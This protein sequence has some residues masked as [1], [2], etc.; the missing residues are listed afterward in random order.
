MKH[1]AVEKLTLS[2]NENA[3]KL[4]SWK[5]RKCHRD[6]KWHEKL[7]TEDK[8]S[9]SRLEHTIRTC[10]SCRTQKSMSTIHRL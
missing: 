2:T 10:R 9:S 1:P 4:S 6:Q 7:L 5:G 8:I 3:A